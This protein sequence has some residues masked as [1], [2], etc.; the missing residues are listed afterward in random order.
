MTVK[1]IVTATVCLT[2]AL[3]AWALVEGSRRAAEPSK[4][5][6]PAWGDVFDPEPTPLA[7]D[8]APA[9]DDGRDRSERA[10]PDEPS[11]VSSGAPT[12]K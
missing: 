2:I 10:P 11:D 7:D 3:L 9:G 12:A 5:G 4:R 6:D 1:S 8:C